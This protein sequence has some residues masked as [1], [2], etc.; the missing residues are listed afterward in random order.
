M[1]SRETDAMHSIGMRGD[2]AGR[3]HSCVKALDDLV[4]LMAD[5]R[6]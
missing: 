2:N 5:Q 1:Y 6:Q 3:R 4:D